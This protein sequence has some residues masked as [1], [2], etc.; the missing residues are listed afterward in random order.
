[1][2][3]ANLINHSENV[4]IIDD[5]TANLVVLTAIIKGAGY[6]PR[7]VSCIKQA[8]QAIDILI[9]HLILLDITLPEI[10]GFKF[11]E[12]LK[13]DGLTRDIPVIFISNIN[14]SQDKVR[15][16]KLG[17]VDFITKPF[18]PNEVTIKINTHIQICK[19]KKDMEQYD[20]QIH[21]LVYDHIHKI[22]ENEKSLIYALAKLLETT[23]DIKGKHLGKIKSNCRILAISLQLSPK[24]MNE[25]SDSFI[26]TIDLAA[27]LHDVGKLNVNDSILLK[28]DKLTNDEMEIVKTH[29]EIG[30]NTLKEIYTYNEKNEYLKMAIDIAYYH[31]EKW[32]GKGYPK[33]LSGKDI[34]L[35]ARIMAVIDVYDALTSERCYKTAYTHEESLRI[36][37]EESGISFDPDIIEVF[38]KIEKRLLKDE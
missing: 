32:N 8:L 10:D 19:M 16:F 29:C 26:N 9:P 28:K 17:A 20:R 24:F 31:H 34:P 11:C 15:G 5:V 4:L 21:K 22:T 30:A 36:M 18:E 33:G 38:N 27:T 25:I 37:N 12:M 23:K 7:P 2:Y 1:M 35:P 6:I 3:K 14:S 13:G